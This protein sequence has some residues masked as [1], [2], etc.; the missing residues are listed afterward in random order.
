LEEQ[1]RRI[2]IIA[3]RTTLASGEALESAC[4][5]VSIHSD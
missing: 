5:I 1:D 2:C 3:E 4:P